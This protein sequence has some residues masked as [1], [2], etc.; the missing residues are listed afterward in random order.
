MARKVLTGKNPEGGREEGRQ[1]KPGP[2]WP[3][4]ISFTLLEARIQDHQCPLPACLGRAGEGGEGHPVQWEPPC[5]LRPWGLG[6]GARPGPVDLALSWERVP[7]G[8]RA[9]RLGGS[10]ISAC[11]VSCS[12][13][14][15]EE[16]RPQH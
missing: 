16:K 3:S 10:M 11:I 5:S 12:M 14:P 1:L 8:S 7:G 6:E 2:V 15:W 9:P 13:E 4:F